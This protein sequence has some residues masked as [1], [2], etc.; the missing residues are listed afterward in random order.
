METRCIQNPPF[1][2]PSGLRLHTEWPWSCPQ[3]GSQATCCG[4]CGAVFFFAGI[5]ISVTLCHKKTCKK[6]KKHRRSQWSQHDLS[7]NNN[8]SFINS[9]TTT[10]L[11]HQYIK[12]HQMY[13]TQLAKGHL[14]LLIRAEVPG[15][16]S[17]FLAPSGQTMYLAEG[18]DPSYCF[19]SLYRYDLSLYTYHVHIVYIEFLEYVKDW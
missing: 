1:S 19:I 3:A 18:Y 12:R 6:Q 2:R 10:N 17:N 5:I 7:R 9:Q 15:L 11:V 16:D 13:L 4:V 8:H 14:H